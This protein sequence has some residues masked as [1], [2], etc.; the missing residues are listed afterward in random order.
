M[1]LFD[2]FKTKTTN[3]NLDFVFKSS[4]HIRYEN[5]KHVSGPHGRAN[6]AIKVEPNVNGGEG[7]TVTLFN[8]DGNHP[9]WQNNV[10]MAPKQMKIIQAND[11]LIILRGYGQDAMGASFSD[12]GLT[13][14]LLNNEID[15]C[16]LHMHDRNIDVE[17]IKA[18]AISQEPEFVEIAKNAISIYDT[19]PKQSIKL[20]IGVYSLVKND[21]SKLNDVSDNASIGKAFL[22][23]LLEKLSNDINNLQMISSIAYLF[24]TKAINN[25]K[26]NIQL[27]IDRLI[28][29]NIGHE[30]I[31]HILL[32]ALELNNANPFTPIG[33]MAPMLA[34]D[35]IFE[36]EFA[37]L[38]SNPVIYNQIEIFRKKKNELND[39][40]SSKKTNVEI[41]NKGIEHHNKLQAYLTNR[42]IVEKNIDF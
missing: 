10:Q 27:Y 22:M 6:R 11:K 23:M 39:Y 12:Y 17:Y 13:I 8:M 40:F 30:P 29:F 41:I 16:T 31:K 20:L 35:A 37:D 14:H 19:D 32:E 9:V 7:Y 21:V 4:D 28:L 38:E 36:M 26:D 5:G 42:V 3:M 24:I 1:G 33:Q 34:R 25:N 2:F 15:K 18:Q